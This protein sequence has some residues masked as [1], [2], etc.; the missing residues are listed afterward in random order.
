MLHFSGDLQGWALLSPQLVVVERHRCKPSFLRYLK[1][2]RF[3]GI[4]GAGI[5]EHVSPTQETLTRFEA[6][7]WRPVMERKRTVK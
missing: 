1:N 2:C 3:R 4:L 6:P 7:Q 5:G